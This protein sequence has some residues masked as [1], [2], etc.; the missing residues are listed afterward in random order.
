MTASVVLDPA[1]NLLPAKLWCR[2]FQYLTVV[3]LRRVRLTCANWKRLVD[4]DPALMERVTLRFP[5]GTNIDAKFRPKCVPPA[6]RGAK[7]YACKI[8]TVEPWWPEIGRNLTGLSVERCFVPIS[9]LLDMLRR[10]P[11]LK[12][13]VLDG[14]KH[15]PI[16]ASTVVDFQLE[17]LEEL[18]LVNVADP[19]LLNLFCKLRSPLKKLAFN[20]AVE[21]SS[22]PSPETLIRAVQ[23]TE[24]TLEEL[25]A[26][27]D[28]PLMEALPTMR[29]LRLKRAAYSWGRGVAPIL[30][31]CK[32]QPA[33]EEL[34]I[35]ELSATDLTF[36]E[37][38]TLL[39]NLRRL[40]V[41]FEWESTALVPSFL[42][43]IPQLQ[44]VSM[45]GPLHFK[46]T[47]KITKL[48]TF[49]CPALLEFRLNS[50]TIPLGDMCQ[51]FTNNPQITSV[52]LDQCKFGRWTDLL[53]ALKRLPNLQRLKLHK[54]WTPNWNDPAE[55]DA[56]NLKYLELTFMDIPEAA[57]IKLLSYLPKLE[58]LD[59]QFV[60]FLNDR[61][62]HKF[63][64][65]LPKL[66]KLTI[67]KCPI[68]DTS[69]HHINLHCKSLEQLDL[70]QTSGL[71]QQ[72][73]NQLKSRVEIVRFQPEPDLAS[74]VKE[75]TL[76]SV[77]LVLLYF[78]FQWYGFVGIAIVLPVFFVLELLK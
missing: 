50:F 75:W 39:P 14:V 28:A 2:V 51:F 18:T 45:E 13:L 5:N 26:P 38:A 57:L 1:A 42:D 64:Q 29:R 66:T 71:S 52:T 34:D 74:K 59:A 3:Q 47:Q 35:S 12:R 41:R 78:M 67:R 37:I 69:L 25:R 43:A 70:C 63:C 27:F 9:T 44:A 68:S 8:S 20:S 60:K 16:F 62:V 54:V 55:L 21:S 23:D 53:G 22:K 40:S 10:T 73:V 76:I 6:A 56:S 11:N 33:L 4:G 46:G 72:V 30:G 58:Q 19:E 36:N 77:C 48:G 65:R 31:F 49:H 17:Q 24:G 15:P 7:F 32:L 61:V